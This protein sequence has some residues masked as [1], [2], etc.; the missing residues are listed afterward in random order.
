MR[1]FNRIAVLFYVTIVLFIGTV[2]VSYVLH[3]ID[4]HGLAVTLYACYVDYKLRMVIGI[5]GGVLL[6]INFIFYNMFTVNVHREKIIAFDNPAGRV[7]VSLIAMEDIV[8]KTVMKL[9]DVNEVKSDI[10]ATKRGL[11]LKVRLSLC[12]EVNIPEF[13]S[14]IQETI[15]DKIQDMIGLD[16]PLY[17]SIYVGKILLPDK[18]NQKS[19]EDS[20]PNDSDN[21]MTANIPFRGY[22]A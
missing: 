14:K 8:K 2:M 11:R 10:R 7:R 1:F 12:S 13:A 9:G 5:T 6:F 3:W 18:I 20:D 21:P 17:I 4:F 16:E 22:R 15:K 19:D